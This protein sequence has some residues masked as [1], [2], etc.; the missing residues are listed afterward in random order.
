MRRVP[1]TEPGLH[2]IIA[3]AD[4]VKNKTKFKFNK[5]MCSIDVCVKIYRSAKSHRYKGLFTKDVPSDLY[6]SLSTPPTPPR[7]VPLCPLP[8][9][10]FDPP[11]PWGRPFFN[12]PEKFFTLVLMSFTVQILIY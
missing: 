1:E 4:P 2:I 10:L 8:Y 11:L 6:G 5:K 12:H 9:K 3:C 7:F